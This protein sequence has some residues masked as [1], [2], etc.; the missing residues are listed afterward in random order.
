[1]LCGVLEAT[2]QLEDETKTVQ[3][4]EFRDIVL[5]RALV[6]PP[7]D[8]KVV[9]MMLHL[10]PR[11]IGTK[12]ND[13]TWHEF[14][15]YSHETSSN[16]HVENCSG[17]ILIHYANEMNGAEEA[18]ET[19][20]EWSRLKVEY[21]DALLDCKHTVKTKDFYEKWSNFGIQYGTR[22]QSSA[23]SNAVPVL[24]YYRSSIS[25]YHKNLNQ[26]KWYRMCYTGHF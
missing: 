5:N 18:A 15:V 24:R 7:E 11:K 8:E 23:Q 2:R 6:I 20:A 19:A 25:T 10:K 12:A 13:T 3:S 21:E 9:I 22:F 26:Q 4:Y 17:L 1:M 14:T 16:E